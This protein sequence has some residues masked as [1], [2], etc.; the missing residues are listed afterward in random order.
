MVF[1]PYIII[2]L[3]KYIQIHFL[4]KVLNYELFQI[5][6][7]VNDMFMVIFIFMNLIILPINMLLNVITF[8]II[9]FINIIDYLV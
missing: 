4:I 1:D 9:N 7:N 5:S 8:I 2:Y 6:N 3:T